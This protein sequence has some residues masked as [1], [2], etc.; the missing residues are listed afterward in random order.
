M[1]KLLICETPTCE[2]FEHK[3]PYPDPAEI[4]ICAGC[5]GFMRVEDPKE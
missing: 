3:I 4:C 2:N 5:N 1:I